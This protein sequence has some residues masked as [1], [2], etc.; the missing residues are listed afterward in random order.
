MLIAPVAVGASMLV[1]FLII[2]T[3]FPPP[4]PINVCLKSLNTETFQL[5][6]R[7]E[8]F[9]DGHQKWL[10]ADVGR[11]PQ[12]GKDCVRPIRTDQIGDVVHIEYIRPI[13]LNLAD[14]MKVYTNNSTTIKVVD[15]S[16][17]AYQNQTIN[18]PDYNI[19]YSYYTANSWQNVTKA[20]DTPAFPTDNKLLDRISLTRIK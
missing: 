12:H 5:Y 3:F 13:R 16:T 2:P 1:T 15:N 19:Q 11:A 18:L 4:L 17:G 20:S 14:F 7:V 8:V 9:V 10:P 6:P